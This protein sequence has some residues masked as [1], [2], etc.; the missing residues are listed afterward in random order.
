[1]LTVPLFGIPDQ[2]NYLEIKQ[3][4]LPED[5][6]KLAFLLQRERVPITYWVQISLMYHRLG[7][8]QSFAYLL[9][10]AVKDTD[11]KTNPHLFDS[12]DDRLKAFNHLAI[13]YLLASEYE[14][15]Q[16]T[17]E[18]L[19]QKGMVNINNADQINLSEPETWLTKC[20]FQFSMGQMKNAKIQYLDHFDEKKF[21]HPLVNVLKSIIEFNQGNYK[22]SLKILKNILSNN[23]RSPNYIR[24]AIGLCYF[25]IGNIEKARFA[26]Q[27]VIELEP[28]HE[29]A[30]I[31]LAI[32]EISTQQDVPDVQNQIRRLLELAFKIN[33]KN[34]LTLRYLAEHY[35]QKRSY[36]IAQQL[37]ENALKSLERCRR[38]EATIKENPNFRKELEQLKSDIYFILGKINHVQENYQDALGF[39]SKAVKCNNYNFSAQF[40]LGKVHYSFNNFQE[41]ENCLDTVLSNPKHKDCYEALRL[42]AQTKSRQNKINEAVEL[43]KRVLELNPQDFEAN[44]EIAQ[45]FEQTEPKHALVY[46]EGGLKILQNEIDE[47]QHQE[48]SL[49]DDPNRNASD[50][51]VPPEILLNVGTL[52]LEVGKILEAFESFSASIKN[53]QKLIQLKPDDNRFK[54]ILITAKFN[55]GYWFELQ[56]RLGEASEQYKQITSQE[57]SYVDAYLRLAYL[58]RNRGDMKRAL[59]YVEIAK[60]KQIKKPEEFSRPV[61]QFCLKGKFYSDISEIQKASDEFKFVNEKLSRDS[62]AIIG[63]A[64]LKYEISTRIRQDVKQQ[65]SYLRNAMDKYI[66]VLETDESNAFAALG[67]ANVLAEHGKTSESMEIYKAVKENSPAIPHPLINQAHLCVE[68]KNLTGAINLYKKALEKFQGGRDL[69]V[70]L[71]LSKAYYKMMDFEN[72]KKILYQ[73]MQRYP[74]DLRLKFNLGLCLMDQARETFNKHVRKVS[75]TK[76]AIAQLHHSHKL[77]LHILRTGSSQQDLFSQHHYSNMSQDQ[78]QMERINFR[79]MHRV[80]DDKLSLIK[81]MIQ[82]GDSYLSHDAEFEKQIMDQ[83]NNKLTK[84]KE[85]QS[86]QEKQEQ[87]KLERQRQIQEQEEQIAE[88]YAESVAQLA[89]KN[90]IKEKKPKHNESQGDDGDKEMK[91]DSD[92]DGIMQD[93]MFHQDEEEDKVFNEDDESI[94][95]RREKKKKDKKDKKDKKKKDKKDKKDKKKKKKKSRRENGEN[96]A[97]GEGNNEDNDQSRDKNVR[98]LKLKR[99]RDIEEAAE[100]EVGEQLTQHNQ[101]EEDIIRDDQNEENAE[102]N[103]E[104]ENEQMID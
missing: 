13:F 74:H 71:Y 50:D 30:V 18:K 78:L 35:F 22:E 33:H 14:V 79:E 67:V 27:R 2:Q 3:T 59:E 102:A 42:L 103:K 11:K 43:F 41:A 7:K 98:R 40:C 9:N 70:E 15:D 62:Y 26:F 38:K 45:M 65:E 69:E 86:V 29:M 101:D 87:D 10:E 66:A 92:D 25:R 24:Y 84:I 36:H 48:S 68:H 8:N 75:E 56:N 73:L 82:S 90:L 93:Y 47:R 76:E 54:A 53:C 96:N 37:C 39:Y 23:P 83:E 77:I 51:I 16:D 80:C 60:S 99:N 20:I 89:L 91:F 57:P 44:F 72:C 34:P 61:N 12:I 4:Q 46:Y 81:E 97:N 28:D 63:M 85:I 94:H 32:L 5:V 88:K 31:S 55:L 1:M 58:A 19:F 52:R 21:S 17:V 100:G 95:K 64:N 104:S 6:Q 49:Q